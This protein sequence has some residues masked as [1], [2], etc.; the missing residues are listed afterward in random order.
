MSLLA[1]AMFSQAPKELAPTEDQGYIFGIVDTPSNSTLDQLTPSI[2][3]VNRTVMS[4]PESE[5]TFQVTFP[6]SGFW[7]AVFKP[8]EERERTA[9]EILPRSRPGRGDPRHP[10]VP[11]P[12]ACAARR[13][14]VPGRVRH[15]LDRREHRDPGLREEAPGE[16][17]GE[18]DVR[19]PAAHRREDRPAVVGDRDRSREGGRARARS[20]G[21]WARISDPRWAGTTSTGSASAGVATR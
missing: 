8:W 15:R 12:P 7:G 3:E 14:T 9:F 10:D 19:V 5:F 4:I 6:T 2:R 18:R 11:D 16:G 1:V 17:D 13:R 21:R 20:P